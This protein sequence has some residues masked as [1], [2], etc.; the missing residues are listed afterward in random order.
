[1]RLLIPGK[2]KPSIRL[3]PTQTML[4]MKLSAILVLAVSLHVSAAGLS[5]KVT[6]S[7]KNASLEEVFEIL[8]KQCGYN[9]IFN[10]HVLAK[11]RKIDIDVK[12]A[13]VEDVLTICFSNQPLTYIIQDKTIVVKEKDQKEEKKTAEIMPAPTEP[14]RRIA[15]TVKDENNKPV[16][17]AA[18]SI[19]KLGIGVATNK[20]G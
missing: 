6:I 4:V 7:K 17:G 20:D 19:K 5:Q 18:V 12:D 2:T 15:G 3:L 10:S 14:P 9:F 16:E 11:A 1:M 8:Q 13:A